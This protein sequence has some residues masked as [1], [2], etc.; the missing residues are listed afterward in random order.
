M[1]RLACGARTFRGRPVRL[2]TWLDGRP[3]ATTRPGPEQLAGLGRLVARVDRALAGFEHP[4][5][6]R[7]L[8][9][10]LLEAPA[11]AGFADLL[12]PARR[13][14]VDAVFARHLD[15]VAPRLAALPHQVIHND[16]NEHNV[17]VAE[18]GAVCGLIDF[19]DT[20]WSPRVCGLAVAA[21]YAMQGHPDPAARGRTR[22]PRIPRGRPAQRRGARGR[23]STSRAPGSR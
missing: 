12:D 15:A 16:A 3:W 7:R 9:W 1:P 21:A 20:V 6:R 23:C 17:L 4:A 19:G 5:M 8:L 18:D 11:V 2:L 10:N 22:R 14:L 13:A